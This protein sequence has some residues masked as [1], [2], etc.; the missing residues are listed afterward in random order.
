MPGFHHQP[1]GIPPTPL[2]S[3][4][5]SFHHSTLPLWHLQVTGIQLESTGILA[6]TGF[7]LED[8]GRHKVLKNRHTQVCRFFVPFL[9]LSPTT[10]SSPHALPI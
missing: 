3:T 9:P 5:F 8:G 4:P 1:I 7:Q 2:E 10:I 6:S